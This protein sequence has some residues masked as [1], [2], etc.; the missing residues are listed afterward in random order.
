M[1]G[2]KSEDLED[3]MSSSILDSNEVV[4][5]KRLSYIRNVLLPFSS[6]GIMSAMFLVIIFP[7]YIPINIEDRF[8]LIL[9][10]AVAAGILLFPAVHIVDEYISK[11]NMDDEKLLA[12]HLSLSI[13]SYEN[14]DIEGLFDNLSKAGSMIKTGEHFHPSHER[15]ISEYISI[16]ENSEDT[17]EYI[18]RYFEPIICATLSHHIVIENWA[19]DTKIP[20][21]AKQDT[22]KS[23]Y[24]LS[25][26][27]IE[28]SLSGRGSHIL[29]LVG[30]VSIII[31]SY[32]YVGSEFAI[33]IATILAIVQRSSYF[34]EDES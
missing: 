20:T 10:V 5:Y 12:H 15:K 29:K 19:S 23:Y 9:S 16:L 3:Y 33:V 8:Y 1:T 17:E 32:V 28:S 6:F 22:P 7:D 11:Y 30:I 2:E 13:K 18:Q 14:G 34:K 4:E 24:Q 27:S 21:D 25:I 31:I 26:E